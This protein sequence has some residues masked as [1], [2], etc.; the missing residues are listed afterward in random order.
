MITE[1][2]GFQKKRKKKKPV[3]QQKTK[4]H[5]KADT[6]TCAY[7][8]IEKSLA[9]RS[10]HSRQARKFGLF[11]RDNPVAP[12]EG[13][14]RKRRSQT[15][16]SRLETEGTKPRQQEKAEEKQVAECQSQANPDTRGQLCLIDQEN[17]TGGESGYR[18]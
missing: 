18:A 10:T 12:R 7:T 2:T 14:V 8:C 15:R 17:K 3:Q 13:K 5:T 16:K 11:D 9:H 1:D 4:M 6:H